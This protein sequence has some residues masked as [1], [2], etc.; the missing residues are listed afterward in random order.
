[1][2]ADG[3]S[4]RRTAGGIRVGLSAGAGVAAI[5]GVGVE[6]GISIRLQ[7]GNEGA[8]SRKQKATSRKRLLAHIDRL[9]L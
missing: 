1:M 5:G 9:A 2:A 3:V 6:V 4:L 8:T 7:A